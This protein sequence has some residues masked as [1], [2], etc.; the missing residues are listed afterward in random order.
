MSV[1]MAHFSQQSSW[2]TLSNAVCQAPACSQRGGHR[3]QGT[4]DV[5]HASPV[6]FR[7]TNRLAMFAFCV[8]GHH[9]DLWL[10]NASARNSQRLSYDAASSS[11]PALLQCVVPC[12]VFEDARRSPAA[13]AACTAG[14]P[15]TG[16]H[17]ACSDVCAACWTSRAARDG[18]LVVACV[19]G[20]GRGEGRGKLG[21]GQGCRARAG[22]GA[23]AFRVKHPPRRHR[24][25]CAG[26]RRRVC[27]SRRP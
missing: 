13:R 22:A 10:L 3:I 21:R 26:H 25:R 4:N 15:S 24:G 1:Y 17:V 9:A 18:V 23:T 7:A 6:V 12:A 5:D 19:V 16:Q 27:P 20:C 14:A 11:A 2:P 8:F